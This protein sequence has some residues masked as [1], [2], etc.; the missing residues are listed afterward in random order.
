M[1][2]INKSKFLPDKKWLEKSELLTKQL[3]DDF[4]K[5]SGNFNPKFG[6]HYKGIKDLLVKVQH[7]KCCYCERSSITKGQHGDVEHFRP[8]QAYKQKMSD[9]FSYPGYYWLGN[10]WD[11]LFLSCA[12][13]N[14]ILKKNLFPIEGKR[15]N[16]HKDK[17]NIDAEEAL[18]IHPSF[19]NPEE[20]ITF[21]KGT[22]KTG[23][24]KNG[25]DSKKGQKTIEIF[26][27]HR[28][29]PERFSTYNK[30]KGYYH[31]LNFDTSNDEK[32]KNKMK[33]ELQY[34][35]IEECREVL[36]ELKKELINSAKSSSEF[37]GMVRA[38]FPDLPR[39]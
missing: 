1:I 12:E 14:Q 18:L 22:A 4:E 2:Q 10:E 6:G 31:L 34:N 15:M 21:I 20:H 28:Y 9:S 35:T 37:A 36:N 26:D 23:K 33:D 30:I 7:D 3:C 29:E 19:D 11:N 25:A 39:D 17:L 24:L 38:N 8:K 16:S 32:I 27:L 13:C 5:S